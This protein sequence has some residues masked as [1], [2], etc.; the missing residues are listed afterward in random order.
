MWYRVSDYVKDVRQAVATF[1]TL[2][3]L[4]GHSM[5][6]LAVQK[7]LERYHAL[8][9]VW[10]T[11][12]P[13]HGT[14]SAVARLFRR[15][16]IALLKATF[17]LRLQPFISTREI[18]RDLF[19]TSDTPQATVD[20]C[21]ARLV[22]ESYLAFLDTMF[23]L[24][25]PRRIHVPV[26]VLGAGRDGFFTVGETQRTGRAYGTEAE[27]FASMGHDMMLDQGWRNVASRIDDWI[28]CCERDGVFA[29]AEGLSSRPVEDWK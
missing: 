23:V 21:F 14:L 6:G 27:I 18:V 1:S 12:F 16:P 24:P 2:P 28:R 7:Y 25:R 3:V 8:G 5:G 13:I 4:V 26:L 10:M 20:T 15:H 11:P 9:A 17:F 29:R 22:D 19:F